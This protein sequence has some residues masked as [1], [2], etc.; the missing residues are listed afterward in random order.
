MKK[1]LLALHK[2][3]SSKKQASFILNYAYQDKDYPYN[4]IFNDGFEFRRLFDEIELNVNV[5][6]ITFYK[7]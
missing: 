5:R 3:V 7:N 2:Y 4:D 1:L 6:N